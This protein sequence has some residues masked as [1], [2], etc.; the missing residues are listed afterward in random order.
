M[1]A[2][3]RRPAVS[4]PAALLPGALLV[5][6][7]TAGA[8]GSTGAASSQHTPVTDLHVVGTR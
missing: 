3:N 5:A 6:V 8:V 1:H 4:W 7:I 2:A